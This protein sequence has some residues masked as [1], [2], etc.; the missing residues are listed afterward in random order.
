[1]KKFAES[2]S[3][4]YRIKWDVALE[5]LLPEPSEEPA[6][7]DDDLA[8]WNCHNGLKYH[9]YCQPPSISI[10]FKYESVSQWCK[11]RSQLLYTLCIV[12]IYGFC[13][14][15]SRTCLD[16]G[17]NCSMIQYFQ[18]PGLIFLNFSLPRNFIVSISSISLFSSPYLLLTSVVSVWVYFCAS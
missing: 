14:W 9:R 18:L 12:Y 6:H 15:Q 13:H 16:L 7:A 10:I 1:M 3:H 5:L 2:D 8:F 4:A 11:Y 17:A